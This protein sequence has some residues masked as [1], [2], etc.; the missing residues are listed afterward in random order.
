MYMPL[1]VPEWNSGIDIVLI[2]RTTVA[3]DFDRWELILNS[4]SGSQRLSIPQDAVVKEMSTIHC[5]HVCM[6]N[7]V[8]VLTCMFMS[9]VHVMC[10]CH[11]FMSRVHV[12]C[13]CHVFTPCVH[14]MCSC[15][16]CMSCVHVMCSCHVFVSCVRV[17]RSC[18]VF[19]S[20]VHVMC[21]CHMFM[22]CVHVMCSCHVTPLSVLIELLKLAC[23]SVTTVI[24]VPLTMMYVCMY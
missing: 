14:V 15:H 17:M 12:M 13:S 1:K 16:V 9:R 21:S 2:P 6:S 7:Y 8:R 20:C 24:H 5:M 4:M 23:Y 11:V 19:M 22:S 18:H 3:W 10:S